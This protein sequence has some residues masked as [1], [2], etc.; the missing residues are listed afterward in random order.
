MFYSSKNVRNYAT[1][2][3]M[4]RK[5]INLFT[6]FRL[7]TE[8][9]VMDLKHC[10]P[11]QRCPWERA[12]DRYLLEHVTVEGTLRGIPPPHPIHPPPPYPPHCSIRLSMTQIW[13]LSNTGLIVL[14]LISSLTIAC[15]YILFF[16]VNAFVLIHQIQT[17]K[18]SATFRFQL[19]ICLIVVVFYY[20]FFF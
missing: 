12:L 1:F 14:T 7:H 11:T 6:Y 2:K 18:P 17:S 8:R 19:Q 5:V 13:L 16:N 10:I 20:Y 9:K 15:V 3:N 4:F